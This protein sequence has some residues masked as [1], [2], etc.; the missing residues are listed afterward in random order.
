LP[1]PLKVGSR[2]SAPARAQNAHVSRISALTT[3]PA[4]LT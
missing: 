2:S 3:E 1:L 4:K